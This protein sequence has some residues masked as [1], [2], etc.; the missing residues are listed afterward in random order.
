MRVLRTFTPGAL[1]AADDATFGPVAYFSP[2]FGVSASLPQYAGGLGILAGDHLKAADA[3]GVPLVGVGLFYHQGYFTQRVDEHGRQLAEFP[4]LDPEALGLTEV[5]GVRAIV[6]I[7]GTPVSI[8]VWR[9]MVG[10]VPLYLLDTDVP[11]NPEPLRSITDRLYGG[12]QIER[13]R[14]ELVLGIGGVRALA[15]LGIDP[16]VFHLNEGHAGFSALERIRRVMVDDGLDWEEALAAVRPSGVFTTH[17]P[18]PAGIDR[19]PGRLVTDHLRWWC[20]EVGVTDARLLELG[21]EPGTPPDGTFNMAVMSLRLSGTTNGVSRLHGEVSRR[22]FANLWP[23]QPVA[24]VPIGAI[25]NGVDPTTWTAP[26]MADLLSTAVGPDWATAAAERWQ[27]I[28]HVPDADLWAV[29]N[30]LRSRMVDV[31]RARLGAAGRAGDVLD[32]DVLT[33]G[34]ARRF[35][36]YKRAGLLL[37]DPDRLRALLDGPAGPAQMVFAGKAHPADVDGQALIAAVVNGARDA[38][39][40]DRLVFVPDYDMDLAA[41]LVS[42]C[43]VWLNTPVRPL[44]ACGTSG[45]KA[46]YNGGLNC[47]VADGWWQEWGDD[48]RGWIIPSAAADTVGVGEAQR[49]AADCEATFTVLESG[50][51]PLFANR[52]AVSNGIGDGVP[53]AWLAKVRTALCELGPLVAATRMV[54]EYVRRAYRPADAAGRRTARDHH[55]DATNTVR[56]ERRAHAAWPSVG[57]VD[58]HVDDLGPGGLEVTATITLDALGLSDVSVEA[59]W[60]PLDD[61]GAFRRLAVHPMTVES[62]RNGGGTP[63]GVDT[64]VVGYRC[65]IPTDLLVSAAVPDTAP[66]GVTVR[67]VPNRAGRSRPA[68]DTLVT[69]A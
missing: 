33:F 18:V 23:S 44:E 57:I 37:G 69:W 65:T 43:D 10:S 32:P 5:D 40:D 13:I 41:A 19:F 47:S 58:A 2:E 68:D 48:R 45:M 3:L 56:F 11:E 50:V 42:G 4:H 35:A 55:A 20:A 28:A 27:E 59:V 46:V 49:D 30:R 26:A 1:A 54:D 25:T 16:T 61:D 17:T 63:A 38:G 31:V 14:Q 9:T 60:G 12:G 21:H 64:G 39:L 51:V 67:V 8:R 24:G 6:D 36:T 53:A 7:D 52:P 22:M 15:G 62:P 66:I 29:R 34:F